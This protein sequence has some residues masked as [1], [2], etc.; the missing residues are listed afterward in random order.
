MAEEDYIMAAWQA[1]NR[2]TGEY[3]IQRGRAWYL[4]IIDILPA[5]SLEPWE[6]EC[7]GEFVVSFIDPAHARTA[8]YVGAPGTYIFH[9]GTKYEGAGIYR[10][11]SVLEKEKIQNF[12]ERME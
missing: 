9:D 12:L 5:E 4:N 11:M 7:Y 8:L 1:F 2:E 6:K 3:E 10:L